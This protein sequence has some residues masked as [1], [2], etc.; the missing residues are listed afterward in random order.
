MEPGNIFLNILL[1][2]LLGTLLG[3]KEELD[4]AENP[5]AKL[6]GGFRTHSIVALLGALSGILFIEGLPALSIVLSSGVIAL[7][8]IYYAAGVFSAKVFGITSEIATI[9][10]HIV[11]VLII[12]Q[13][14]PI[15]LTVALTVIAFFILRELYHLV[16]CIID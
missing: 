15:K 1:A 7:V 3:L 12:T 6:L 11:G 8:L 10:A 2:I 5:K 9:L 4:K 14:L 13:P 16:A